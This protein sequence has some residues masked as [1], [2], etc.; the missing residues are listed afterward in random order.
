MTDP[1]YQPL[2]WYQMMVSGDFWLC[3]LERVMV[4][5]GRA[6]FWN[7]LPSPPGALIAIF[8]TLSRWYKCVVVLNLPVKFTIGCMPTTDE[9]LQKN[10]FIQQMTLS[11]LTLMLETEDF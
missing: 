8:A 7:S 2:S 5:V 4:A 11:N 1:E 6:D 10:F 9:A 3:S